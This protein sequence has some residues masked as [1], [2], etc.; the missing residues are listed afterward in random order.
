[1]SIRSKYE[2]LGVE[3]FYQQQGH[4]YQNP[5][6]SKLN[7]TLITLLNDVNNFDNLNN[8]INSCCFSN[9][10]SSVS[11]F[12]LSSSNK[13]SILRVM[14]LCCGSGEGTRAFNSWCDKL[15]NNNNNNKSCFIE[16]IGIDPYTFE[17]YKNK[18]G[19]KALNFS[20]LDIVKGKLLEYGY[21]NIC[22]CSFALH[23]AEHSVLADVLRILSQ[24]VFYLVILT[25][26]KR[27]VIEEKNGWKCIKSVIIERVHGN[28]YQSLYF[29]A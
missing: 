20:F 24:Q 18:T 29:Q 28:L 6:E 25:P 5:H 4:S 9:F 23:L 19:Y 16:I 17:L 7:I 26:H 21:Y 14:D 15:N 22:I 12:S 10:S 3:K 8:L 27:P 11:S 13:Q 2:E 1:M